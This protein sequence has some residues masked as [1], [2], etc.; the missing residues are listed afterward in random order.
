MCQDTYRSSVS[1]QAVGHSRY[2]AEH[3]P[4]A[5]YVELAGTDHRPWLGDADSIADA[6]EV[7]L[8]GR[9]S[10]PRRRSELGV[11][12]LS[13]RE[14]EVAMLT[15]RG[16]TA[17]EI[18]SHLGIS[19]RTVETHLVSVYAKLGVSSKSELIRRWVTE[20]GL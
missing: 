18:A 4:A 2:L 16:A 20:F 15:A 3:L 6:V 17:P 8:T 10:R 9:K 5:S 7:F 1:A 12:A 13:R 11:D 19:K 14:H